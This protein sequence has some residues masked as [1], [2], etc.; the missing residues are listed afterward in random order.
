MKNNYSHLYLFLACLIGVNSFGFAQTVKHERCGAVSVANKIESTNPGLNARYNN[1]IDDFKNSGAQRSAAYDTTYFIKVVVHVVYNTP[2]Q[3]L[4]DSVILNQ[5]NILNNDFQRN[6]A[7]T[8]NMRA[9]F[10]GVKSTNSK[11]VFVLS[12]TDEQGNPSTGITR[13]NTTNTTFFDILSGG[14]A[15]GVKST[16]DG[17]IDP[18][19]P[20]RFLNIWVCNM[21]IPIIGPSVLGYAT[22]PDNLPNWDP[23]ASNG[24]ID[25]VVIQFQAFGS[26][27]PNPLTSL[28]TT[29]TVK[30]RT[31]VHEVGHYLG[32]RHIWGDATN[33]TGTDGMD[34]TPSANDAS[35]QDCDANKNTCA[36]NIQGV[37]LPDMIENYM[38]YSSE[39]CQNTFTKMQVDFMRWV[40][41][42]KRP[43]VF[44]TSVAGLTANENKSSF[45]IV[46][47]PASNFISIQNGLSDYHQGELLIRDVFGKLLV[48]QKINS[49]NEN[50]LI[51]VSG[52]NK[53]IY[54]V[55]FSADG[56]NVEVGKFIKN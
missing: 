50:D 28:G 43:Q 20:Q 3:N 9:V 15:E 41:V 10:N 4:H 31:P 21:A 32:L 52:L 25:G 47:N 33:C 42:T 35:A 22:P 40:L 6:N 45:S 46:P 53:G 51:D 26:N 1:L 48:Q 14:L 38:D 11:I 8:V 36:D 30:G 18:W 27:N 37:D 34:D 2:Q 5:I 24:L 16:A 56:G 29:F 13:T 49:M 7:D 19:D 17:G 23:G 54:F 55:S 39:D 44:F 12:N